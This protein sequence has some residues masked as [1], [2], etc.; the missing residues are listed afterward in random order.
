MLFK[1]CRAACSGGYFF[2]A[3]C[4][5]PTALWGEGGY[6]Y[7]LGVPPSLTGAEQHPFATS[8]SPW[9][10]LRGAKSI[11]CLVSLLVCMLQPGRLWPPPIQLA[12]QMLETLMDVSALRL[13]SS[14]KIMPSQLWS[15][16]LLAFSHSLEEILFF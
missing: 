12:R 13:K 9:K 7:H 8:A 2:P 11:C 10:P 14:L 6:L 3:E 1:P 16:A 4:L 5:I 15:S